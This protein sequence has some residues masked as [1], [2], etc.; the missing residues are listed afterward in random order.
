M[1]VRE[2]EECV[3]ERLLIL[4]KTEDETEAAVAIMFFGRSIVM[5]HQ[6][7]SWGVSI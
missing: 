1:V 2:M 3:N 6:L 7:L 5:W 4:L